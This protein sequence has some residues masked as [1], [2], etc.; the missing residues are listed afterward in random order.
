MLQF[1][2][3]VN[4]RKIFSFLW[5]TWRRKWRISTHNLL[6]QIHF[7]LQHILECGIVRRKKQLKHS[8]KMVSLM[9]YIFHGKFDGR[10]RKLF[11]LTSSHLK[12][13]IVLHYRSPS[14]SSK[15]EGKVKDTKKGAIET[16]H[17]VLNRFVTNQFIL[18]S[19]DA[20][21][22]FLQYSSGSFVETFFFSLNN[23]I[24]SP[25]VFGWNLIRNYC[26]VL[27]EW[28]VL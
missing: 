13:N 7:A 15:K 24:Q 14:I 8:N 27:Q 20:I 6:T 9:N 17:N 16:F 26:V 25:P 5:T 28:K 3:K 21:N 4:W 11:N 10:V 19:F 22:Q 18:I 2:Q 23:Y 12:Q 1:V